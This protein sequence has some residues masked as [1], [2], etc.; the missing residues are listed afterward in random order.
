MINTVIER[1]KLYK[2]EQLAEEIDTMIYCDTTEE[3]YKQ[4]EGPLKALIKWSHKERTEF[5]AKRL[6]AFKGQ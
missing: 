5:D 2:L 3:M 6:A 1:D 4:F